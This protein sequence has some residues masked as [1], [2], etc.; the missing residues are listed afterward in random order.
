[1]EPGVES[2]RIP[3]LR[4]VPPGSDEPLLDRV[5]CELRVP[6]D[7]A[8]RLVQPHD[9]RAGELGESVMIA[10]ACALDE[11]SLVHGCLGCGTIW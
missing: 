11:P 7:E 3:K 8:S 5:T 10:F 6:E 9:G 1:M 4:E 2:I